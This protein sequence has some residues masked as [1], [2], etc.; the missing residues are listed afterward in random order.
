M[1]LVIQLGYMIG[2]KGSDDS[3]P[4]EQN[5][6]THNDSNNDTAT[7]KSL[8]INTHSFSRLIM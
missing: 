8:K 5:K 6:S 4:D 3:T 1:L 7:G 2:I